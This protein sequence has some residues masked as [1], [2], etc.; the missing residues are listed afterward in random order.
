[1]TAEKQ[2]DGA[3]GA[4]VRAEYDFVPTRADYVAMLRNAP[5]VRAAKVAAWLMLCVVA[6]TVLM[7][8]LVVDSSG[9]PVGSPEVLSMLLVIG[10]P[11]ALVVLWYARLG[12][13]AA[14]RKP[15]NREPVHAVLGS[16][17][18]SHTGPSGKQSIVWDVASHARET[19]DGYYV[20]V[21]SGLVSM[22]FWL[23]KRAVTAGEQAGVRELIRANV[24][25]YQIR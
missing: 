24:R 10:A 3:L 23:P 8:L 13:L 7:R 4:G 9:E 12:S 22:V 18:F 6:L 19:T 17:G 11:T 15:Q 20:Y 16:D 21:P 2:A 25:R 1:V 14:W 5:M